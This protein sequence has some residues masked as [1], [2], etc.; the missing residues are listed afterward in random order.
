[1]CSVEI[2]S[3]ERELVNLGLISRTRCE[4]WLYHISDWTFVV[5]QRAFSGAAPPRTKAMDGS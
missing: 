3:L 1:M 2:L 5:V 4:W